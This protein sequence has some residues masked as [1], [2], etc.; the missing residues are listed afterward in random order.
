MPS[1]FSAANA[2]GVAGAL[3]ALLSLPRDEQELLHELGK[4]FTPRPS[5]RRLRGRCCV[6]GRVRAAR[7]V[8]VPRQVPGLVVRVPGT[9]AG[10]PGR[11]I[12]GHGAGAAGMNVGSPVMLSITVA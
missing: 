7:G 12:A 1:S 11:V 5:P 6:D 8:D 4:R 3:D 10:S 2:A 9:R